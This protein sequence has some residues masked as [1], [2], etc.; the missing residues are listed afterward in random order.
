MLEEAALPPLPVQGL[1]PWWELGGHAISS[2]PN[3]VD[4]SAI[5]VQP[6]PNSTDVSEVALVEVEAGLTSHA[7]SKEALAVDLCLLGPDECGL[8]Q[9]SSKPSLLETEQAGGSPP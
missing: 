2:P 3:S 6:T 4:V 7:V 1:A 9:T 5:H 8:S